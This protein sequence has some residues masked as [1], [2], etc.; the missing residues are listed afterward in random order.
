MK[1]VINVQLTKNVDLAKIVANATPGQKVVVRVT[2][3]GE[4]ETSR[5]VLKGVDLTLCFE[6]NRDPKAPPLTL[7]P[8]RQ[9]AIEEEALFDL[10][11]GS[12]ELINVR[13]V[14]ENRNAIMP[15]RILRLKG[16]NL[17]LFGELRHHVAVKL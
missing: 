8:D 4:V 12:L 11:G 14:F 3:S 17:R 2:G 6:A 10:D 9:T 1:P 15:K 16:A 5:I 7:V 13:V